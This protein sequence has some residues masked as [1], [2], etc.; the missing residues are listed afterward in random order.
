MWCGDLSWVYSSG[1]GERVAVQMGN[2]TEYRV[3]VHCDYIAAVQS[4]STEEQER[5]TVQSNGIV[6]RYDATILQRY[7]VLV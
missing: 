3:T 6:Q 5:V 2:G 1:I 7:R 4:N